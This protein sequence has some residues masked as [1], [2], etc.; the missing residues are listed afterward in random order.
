MIAAMGPVALMFWARS[1]I[2][3]QEVAGAHHPILSGEQRRYWTAAARVVWT[4]P[5][6][7][8]LVLLVLGL[9]LNRAAFWAIATF[10]TAAITYV[11]SGKIAGWR[12]KV[13]SDYLE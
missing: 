13:R 3:Q 2:S 11:V 6:V 7:S 4:S 12:F 5:S 8:F 9:P 10:A 1:S